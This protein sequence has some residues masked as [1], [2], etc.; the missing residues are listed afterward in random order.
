MRELIMAKKNAGWSRRSTSSTS[1]VFEDIVSIASTLLRGRK[2]SS[3]DKLQ[4]FAEATRE[5]ANS[6]TDLPSIRE[7][8]G[9]AA[10]NISQFANY[11]VHTDIEHMVSDATTL[12]RRNPLATLG[13]SVAVGA[14]AIRMMRSPTAPAQ[15]VAKARARPAKRSAT[16]NRKAS[17][18]KRRGGNG[19]AQAHA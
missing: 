8:V 13:V 12:A 4:Q 16:S 11:V 15:N 6:L 2:E 19:A 9:V 7:Q 17:S 3:G 5:Y 10:E 18:A 1:H 14:L